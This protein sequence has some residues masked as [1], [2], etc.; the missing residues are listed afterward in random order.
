MTL[1]ALLKHPALW[2]GRQQHT[3][4]ETLST[5]YPQLDAVLPASGW[6]LGALTEIMVSSEGI[7]EFSLLM[8]SLH[9]LTRQQQWIALV[10]PPYIPYAPAL[11]AAGISLDRILVVDSASAN[12]SGNSNNGSANHKARQQDDF[13][14]AEQLLRS[15]IFSAVILWTTRT[16]NDRQQ[17]RLQ[18]AAEQGK[19]WAVCYRPEQVANSA[20]PAGLRMT[21]RHHQQHLQIDIIK[22]RGGKCHTLTLPKDN[23]HKPGQNKPEK[24]RQAQQQDNATDTQVTS[25]TTKHRPVQQKR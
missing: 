16:S 1:E 21:L 17:R 14:A 3:D 5:G 9:T 19:A 4:K 11:I 24:N 6:P 20:S 12:H 10:A 7:G 25:I 13:W 23:Q 22:N 15:G 8:P 18:L 2:Q